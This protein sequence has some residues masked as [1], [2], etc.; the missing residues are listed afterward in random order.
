MGDLSAF[1]GESPIGEWTLEIQDVAPG[2]GGTLREFSLEI[3][4]EGSFRPD[5]DGDGV[6]DD[7]D[8][9][10]LG[11]PAGVEVDVTGCPINRL[12]A[13][14]FLVEINSESCS[15]N[16]DGSIEITPVNTALAYTAVLDDGSSSLNSEFSSSGLFENL[17]AGTYSLCISAT[18]GVITYQE[19]C[20]EIVLTEPE[21]LGVVSSLEGNVVSLQLA[22]GS[23]YNVELNGLVTQT[24]DSQIQLDLR[25]GLNTLN[26][27]TNLPCQGNFLRTFVIGSVGILYPN[28]VGAETK[29]FLNQFTG[30]VN[31]K[32][33]SA[34]GRLVMED[35]KT[36]NGSELVMDFSSLATGAYYLRI[37]GEGF[38]DAFKMI[39][40]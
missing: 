2:D 15:N 26:V 28:P 12:P 10:C 37:E 5:E 17:N 22:G 40:Q 35:N 34:A 16:N 18:D 38:N 27:T 7:G 24:E 19:T 4:V 11:T 29:L 9:L 13:D 39:K 21:T 14:N 30:N 6:F 3:C 23:L 20:F 31:L 8:D 25:D 32:V 1:N 33:F 36:I